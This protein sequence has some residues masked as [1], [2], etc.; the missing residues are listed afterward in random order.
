MKKTL[1]KICASFGGVAKHDKIGDVTSYSFIY[2][3][4]TLIVTD[5]KD[6]TFIPMI[7]ENGFNL[8]EF[9]RVSHDTT[10]NPYSFKWNLHSS[11]KDFNLGRLKSRLEFMK[12]NFL[13]T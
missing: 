13:L 12:N 10:I 5:R 7:F 6:N 4:G 11:D 8:Q 3:I 9:L 1:K 2:S